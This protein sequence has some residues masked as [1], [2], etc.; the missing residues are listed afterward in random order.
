MC[1]TN[2]FIYVGNS[3]I[4]AYQDKYVRM[5][6]VCDDDD[7]AVRA[8]RCYSKCAKLTIAMLVILVIIAVVAVAALAVHV[9]LNSGKQHSGEATQVCTSLP[10]LQLSVRLLSSM[11]TSVDPCDDFYNFSCG[12]WDK[13]VDIPPGM[14]LIA[15]T[16]T[17]DTKLCK[18]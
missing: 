16:T 17:E 14:L 4:M 1:F 2:L 12:N 13:V 3:V 8:Q 7:V 10:C 11:N 15:S 5:A 9:L 18:L 6:D